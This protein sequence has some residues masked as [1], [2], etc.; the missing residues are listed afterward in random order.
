M[1]ARSGESP[2]FTLLLLSPRRNSLDIEIP[3]FH[4]RSRIGVDY[5]TPAEELEFLVRDQSYTRQA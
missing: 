1:V 5:N 3:R 2:D 4:L